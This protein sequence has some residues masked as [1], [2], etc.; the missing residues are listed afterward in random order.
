MLTHLVADDF[1]RVLKRRERWE[2]HRRHADRKT[3]QKEE[4][5]A[6]EGGRRSKRK[7]RSISSE[8]NVET[9]VVVDPEMMKYY[10]NEDIEN[11]VLTVMNMVRV[12][13]GGIWVSLF[14]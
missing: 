3:L 10:Q 11:Y 8:K 6:A 12:L 2:R 1:T 7:K 4:E 14:I 5:K 9:L 13:Q